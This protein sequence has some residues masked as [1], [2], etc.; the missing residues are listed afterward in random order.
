MTSPSRASACRGLANG[1]LATG[2]FSRAA[3]CAQRAVDIDP[4]SM[5]ARLLLA[6]AL[7]ALRRVPDAKRAV[8]RV[9]AR[10][11]GNPAAVYLLG[12]V[13]EQQGNLKGAAEA[14][15][16]YVAREPATFKAI[17]LMQR[18]PTLKEAS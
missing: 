3:D 12:R 8:D 11:P 10:E 9:L 16:A 2:D 5:R 17:K 15:R 4:E 18:F 1:F 13:L 14:F 7:V 6:R